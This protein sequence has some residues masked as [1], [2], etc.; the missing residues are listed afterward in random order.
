MFV[1]AMRNDFGLS[2]KITNW[3]NLN[4][5]HCCECSNSAE[6]P[7]FLPLEKMEKYL[8]ESRHM[9][10]QFHEL[11]TIGGG[12]ALAPYMHN[13]FD[14]IPT[15][16]NMIHKYN[17]IPTIK[18]NG[19]WGVDGIMREKILYDLAGAAYK[20]GKLVTLDMSVDEFHTNLSG[21][22]NIIYDILSNMQICM[23]IR[24]CLV[25]FN[26]Q[27]S[28]NVHNLLKRRLMA[29]GIEIRTLPNGDWAAFGPDTSCG[30]LIINSFDTPI[31]NQGRAREN[32]V[33][34][35]IASPNGDGSVNC[36]QL[37][38]KD[39]AIYNYIYHEPVKHRPLSK[40]FDVLINRANGKGY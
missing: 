4:C 7:K 38:N 30:V 20:S 12:E 22:T 17:Y 26:T 21:V 36:L 8:Y 35:S 6:K 14:Y 2:F 29:K 34:T 28:T 9:P 23:A 5:A 18:T 32:K 27:K 3:C 1:A 10:I 37:D 31:Y 24:V 13:N 40:V 33:Y 15:A 39:M 11:L 25:G 19:T 16:L